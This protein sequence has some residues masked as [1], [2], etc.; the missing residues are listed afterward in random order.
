MINNLVVFDF[1]TTGVDIN[2]CQ[3]VQV[4]ALG[5]DFHNLRILDNHFSSFIRPED[6]SNIEPGALSFHA[7]ARGLT[8]SQVLELWRE[9]PDLKVVWNDFSQYVRQHNPTGNKFDAPVPAGHN[10]VNFDLPIY[11]RINGRFTNG[12]PVFSDLHFFDT[13][14]LSL[15]WL[16]AK[17]IRKYNMDSL[18]DYFGMSQASKDHAHDA[19]S[20]VKDT[21]ELLIR[22]LRITR[23]FA[24]KVRFEGAFSS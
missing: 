9:A 7:K 10:I 16:H 21:A 17:D 3:P 14:N 20:D 22:Y 13:M 11:R 1:E 5:I 19:L 23:N 2:T 12:K 8:E 4:A 18:R 15:L 24:S 6:F